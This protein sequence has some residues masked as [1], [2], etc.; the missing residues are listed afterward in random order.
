LHAT[1]D[2]VRDIRLFGFHADDACVIKLKEI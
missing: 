2:L 1:K